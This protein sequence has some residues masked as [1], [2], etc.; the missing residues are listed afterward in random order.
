MGLDQDWKSNFYG[1]NLTKYMLKF[2]IFFPLLVQ[3]KKQR[4]IKKNPKKQRR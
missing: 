2:E 4:T 3:L 1:K